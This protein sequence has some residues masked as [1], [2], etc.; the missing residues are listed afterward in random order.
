MTDARARHSPCSQRFPAPPRHRGRVRAIVRVQSVRAPAI[1]TLLA[2]GSV[3]LAGCYLSHE[4]VAEEGPDAPIGATDVA[5]HSDAPGGLDA[6]DTLDAPPDAPPLDAPGTDAPDDGGCLVGPTEPTATGDTAR[7]ET[8][9][10]VDAV[11]GPHVTAGARALVTVGARPWSI[12]CI[13][14]LRADLTVAW[15]QPFDAD[16]E[17]SHWIRVGDRFA[18]VSISE[19]E[20]VRT[21]VDPASGALGEPT[22]GP[23]VGGS[24]EWSAVTATPEGGLLLLVNEDWEIRVRAYDA[25]LLPLGEASILTRD[26]R[27]PRFA[28]DSLLV[29]YHGHD[30]RVRGP[31][32]VELD[33][34]GAVVRGP[35]WPTGT[36]VGSAAR[37]SGTA[38]GLHMA[39][40]GDDRIEAGSLDAAL[41]LHDHTTLP[42]AHRSILHEL[43]ILPDGSGAAL[44]QDG[45]S[46]ALVA[47]ALPTFHTLA[48]WPDRGGA[49]L[50]RADGAL[51]V[52][53]WDRDGLVA[54][55]LS[56]H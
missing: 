48:R 23:P 34:A 40:W 7:F 29:A 28:D 12:G 26:G 2:L 30:A 15:T 10:P 32:L 51:I 33:G 49:G 6:P 22:F 11:W 47:T 24:F 25:A 4:R 35:L 19:G 16:G 45:A 56:L 36:A 53:G 31:A 42:I 27:Y 54:S 9:P 38:P 41:S 52:L 37:L 1:A 55:R 8:R 18:L 39:W 20:V 5:I 46:G 14:A 3:G 43:L 13:A 44:W 17:H 50:V 21:F